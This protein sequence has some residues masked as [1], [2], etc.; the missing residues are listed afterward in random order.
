[1]N[2]NSY[3]PEGMS[4]GTSE[5]RHDLYSVAALEKARDSGRILEGVATVC[6]EEMA[7]KV[8][9]GPIVGLIPKEEAVWTPEGESVKDIAVI[10]RVGK[11]V[12]FK[13][14]RIEQQGT[15]TVA[16]LSRRLAQAEC[17]N[18]YLASLIPGDVID[19]K[20]TH[21]EP[22]GA[23]ADV[24]CGIVSLLPI[25][26]ISVSRISHPS[27][28]FYPGMEIKA[29]V[30]SIDYET[31]RLYLSQK[32]L[33]GTWEENAAAFAIGQTVSGIV[34]SVESYGIFIELAPNLAGL[35][36]WKEGVFPG[37]IAAVYIK[38]IIPEKMKVKLVLVDCFSASDPGPPPPLSYFEHRTHVD[39]W[40]YSPDCSGK[41]VETVF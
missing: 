9:L 29:V 7:L 41:L 8:D 39:R 16:I 32:E 30:K 11:P 14:L 5:N 26:C 27:D 33:L 12:C 2:G 38:N 28:R 3:K 35:A 40:V 24:G 23:F 4:Y 20:L 13:V 19:A 37:Q 25:D 17:R 21:L 18:A 36:E 10:T 31:G 1:M 15:K 6:T 34:R 22:F